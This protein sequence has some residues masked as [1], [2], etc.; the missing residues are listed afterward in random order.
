MLGKLNLNEVDALLETEVIGR[1]GCSIHNKTHIV[2]VYYAYDGK[3]IYGVSK[4]GNKIDIMRKNP[5]VCFEVEHV[6]NLAHWKTAVVQ[7]EFEEV[8]DKEERKKILQIIHARSM[9]VIMGEIAHLS[10]YWP[11]QPSDINS[12]EGVVYRIAIKEKE[13]RFEKNEIKS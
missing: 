3:Y 5:Q 1:I 8:K 2:P 9:P 7:G 12:I 11:F 10:P 13:G 4:E 6:E